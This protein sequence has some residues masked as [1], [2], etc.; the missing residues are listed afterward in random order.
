MYG[1]PSDFAAT[2][3]AGQELTQVSFTTNT[4]HFS[5]DEHHSITVESTFVYRPDAASVEATQAV[6]AVHSEIMGL[7]GKTVLRAEADRDGVLKLEFLG[8][9]L[10]VFRDDSK[11]YESYQIRIG[12]R[13]ISV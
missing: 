12:K 9:G 11:E 4:V 5:F 2:V 13:Q 6:P 10:L 3:F 8:G 1:L 7:L